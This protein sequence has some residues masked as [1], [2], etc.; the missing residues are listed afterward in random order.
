M[1]SRAE[2]VK[3]VYNE[4]H[5]IGNHSY[6]H[7]NLK[8][9]SASGIQDEINKMSNEMYKILGVRPT[10]VRPPYGAVNDNVKKY[11]E[12]PL[13]NWNVDTL[14][15]ETRDADKVYEEIMDGASDGAIILMHDL[16]A[17]TGEAAVRAIP[18]LKAKGYQLLTVSELFE[19]KGIT[20]KKGV[21][22]YSAK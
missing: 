10:L 20:P 14:D 22:Y 16:Y 18:K 13:I 21:K 4:G 11:V 6:S 5:E 19:A 15:W 8:K 1:A 17:T 3:R 12:Y 9:L 2:T 7:K